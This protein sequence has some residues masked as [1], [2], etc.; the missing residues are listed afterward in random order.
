MRASELRSCSLAFGFISKQL[1]PVP[2]TLAN[3]D[4]IER[5]NERGLL[6]CS[7]A[8]KC[9]R[10]HI[11]STL[12][13]LTVAAGKRRRGGCHCLHVTRCIVC[14]N[15]LCTSVLT[16]CVNN[17]KCINPHTP[18]VNSTVLCSVCFNIA[19]SYT[20]LMRQSFAGY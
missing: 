13:I 12:A 6:W 17:A 5:T 1:A 3:I 8:E 20:V 19:C 18:H 10:F 4:S 11:I 7:P 16:H 2:R 9:L 15:T 14:V